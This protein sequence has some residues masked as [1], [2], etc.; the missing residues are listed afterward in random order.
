L[1]G[2]IADIINDIISMISDI[3]VIISISIFIL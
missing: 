2:Y 3:M 1:D